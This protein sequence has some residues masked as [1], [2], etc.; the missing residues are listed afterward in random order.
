MAASLEQL[1]NRL[2]KYGKWS[3]EVRV[4]LLKTTSFLSSP[5]VFL[6]TAVLKKP[7]PQ[8]CRMIVQVVAAK[9]CLVVHKDVGS[10]SGFLR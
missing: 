1:M 9:I 8:T 10:D 2:A 6:R 4:R 7:Y 3:S 5:L